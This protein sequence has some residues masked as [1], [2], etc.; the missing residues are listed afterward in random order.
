MSQTPTFHI[1]NLSGPQFRALLNQILIALAD[2]NAG[3]TEPQ[4]PFVG[5]AWLDTS[6]TPP[7][8]KLRNEAN[9]GWDKI[10]TAATPPTKA[11]IG[12]DKVPNYSATSS[13]T[14]SSLTKFLLAGA[15]KKLQ[16]NKLDKTGQAYDSAR[17]G[18]KLANQYVL[19]SGTYS[20]LR[21]QATT[22][23]DVGLGSVANYGITNSIT[24]NNSA[25][26]LSAKGGYDLNQKKVDKTVTV[27]G[28]PLSGNITLTASDVGALAAAGGNLS[29]PI[30]Y[31]PDTGDI[32]KVDGKVILRR[33][34]SNG[35]L[36]IGGDDALIIGCGEARQTLQDNVPATSELLHLGSDG[37]V[38]VYTNLQSGW[39][40]RKTFEFQGDGGFKPSNASKTRQN[41]DVPSVGEA[42]KF[43]RIVGEIVEFG[44]DESDIE[45][46][47][48]IMNNTR[49]VNGMNEPAYQELRDKCLG[50]YIIQEGDD[51][52]VVDA[53]DFRRGKGS[54]ARA[55]GEYQADETNSLH[56]VSS[57]KSDDGTTY[58]VTIPENGTYSS[59]LLLDGYLTTYG[60]GHIRFRKKGVQN[61]P[62]SRT[63]L[64][65]L[66]HGVGV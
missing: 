16:D 13:L 2:Q 36:S 51:F 35:G 4:N 61:Q 45:P 63:V 9:S 32:I 3:S 5:M 44:F 64:V 56:E 43:G 23:A 33:I 1:P 37:A 59:K 28:K 47:F 50:K 14:D 54:S 18:N 25:L 6:T 7:I 53:L 49:V 39:G 24:S 46:G 10:F 57:S 41:L 29:G 34:S 21:A 17:L 11:Q 26:Y 31:T 15:G 60:A 27:N 19:I 12:L 20:N 30:N 48:F 65:C 42:K 58:T 40:S 66:Y 52:I 55:I 62:R 38:Y 8:Y 22:K